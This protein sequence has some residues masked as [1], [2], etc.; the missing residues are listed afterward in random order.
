MRCKIVRHSRQTGPF[1]AILN[2]AAECMAYCGSEQPN[3][4]TAFRRTN[5]PQAAATAANGRFS[6]RRI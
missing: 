5:R 1:R 3:I 2:A 4:D 6:S